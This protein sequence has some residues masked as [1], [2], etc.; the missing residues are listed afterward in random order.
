MT[1]VSLS[2]FLEAA[3][4]LKVNCHG[5]IAYWPLWRNKWSTRS[6]VYKW[7]GG[8]SSLVIVFVELPIGDYF[9]TKLH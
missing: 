5:A 6:H 7:H 1:T 3:Y 8:S 4:Q 9:P 2:S